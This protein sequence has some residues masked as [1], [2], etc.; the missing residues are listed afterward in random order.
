MPVDIMGVIGGEK[1]FGDRFYIQVFAHLSF[2]GVTA[3]NGEA[4]VIVRTIR[5]RALPDIIFE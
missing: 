5:K 2:H 3:G 4:D 1:L